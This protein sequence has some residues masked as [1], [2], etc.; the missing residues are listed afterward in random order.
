[1][2]GAVRRWFGVT[3]VVALS[4][5]PVS[6]GS[7]QAGDRARVTDLEVIRVRP[8]FYMIADGGGNIAVQVGNDG[9]VLVDTGSDA[10]RQSVAAAVRRISALPIRFIINTNADPDHVGGNEAFLRSGQAAFDANANLL[11][12][13]YFVSGA[14]AILAS[15][16]VLRRMS[17]PS[18]Q[19]SPFPVAA[20][21]TETF[22]TG[23]RYLYLNDEGIDVVH[24]PSAH[25]DGDATVFFRRSDVIVAGDLFDTTRFPVIDRGRGGS[26]QGTIDALNRL[27]A[28]AIPSQPDVSRD[29]GTSVIPGH[30]H[31]GDQFDLLNYRDMLVIVRDH[32]QDLIKSGRTLEQIKAAAP[33]KGFMARYGS[34]S[35]PW[36]TGDFIEAVYNS[37][38]SRQS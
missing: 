26:L 18:G 19:V 25:T 20:W 14:V 1:V 16:G 8:N 17:A 32:V 4:L 34:D 30:G 5:A 11:P 33:A 7:R 38:V 22:E 37:L 27:I 3:L 2:A 28:T 23:R 29:A 12:K 31:I 6:A 24:Q 35:G 15:E 21:P 36:T 9:L 10:A 13:N